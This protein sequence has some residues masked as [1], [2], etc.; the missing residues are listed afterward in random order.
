M[1]EFT[2]IINK[3]VE[4]KNKLA[5]RPLKNYGYS[6]LQISWVNKKNNNRE[7]LC[8]LYRFVCAVDCI[9]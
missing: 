6:K 3:V 5:I 7:S 1:V 2:C 9:V 8:K 4:W